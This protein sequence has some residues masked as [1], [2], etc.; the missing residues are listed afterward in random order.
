MTRAPEEGLRPGIMYA[1]GR[2]AATPG[3][4]PWPNDAEAGRLVLLG[5]GGG[6]RSRTWDGNF[7]VHPLPPN[8]P[9]TIVVSCV[10]HGVVEPARHQATGIPSGVV[11]TYSFSPQYQRE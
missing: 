9:V 2:R 8:G 6:G 7:W 10:E 11:I 1:D 4:H 5:N 3:D